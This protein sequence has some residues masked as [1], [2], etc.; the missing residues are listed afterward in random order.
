MPSTLPASNANETPLTA[1]TTASGVVN[2]TCRSS[3]ETT[4][5]VLALSEAGASATS[6]RQTG[7]GGAAVA[8]A[9]P[10]DV[11]GNRP[12][13]FARHLGQFRL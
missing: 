3:T 2:R 5:D 1:C 4:G 12:S 6:G 13:V 9:W 11:A 7:L 10:M 8:G